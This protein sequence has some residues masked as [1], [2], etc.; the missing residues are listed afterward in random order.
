MEFMGNSAR[1]PMLN[2]NNNSTWKFRMQSELE[3]KEAWPYVS[4]KKPKP[5]PVK[6]EPTDA[7]LKAIS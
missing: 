2:R 6:E 5:V 4:G 1:I 7:E 3:K